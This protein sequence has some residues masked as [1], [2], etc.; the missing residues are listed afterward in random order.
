[1]VQAA[2]PEE[3]TAAEVASTRTPPRCGPAFFEN[4]PEGRFKIA[5]PCQHV[6]EELNAEKLDRPIEDRTMMPGE[7][8]PPVPFAGRHAC[9]FQSQSREFRHLVVL[10]P[11]ERLKASNILRRDH[12]L[13]KE[14]MQ[15]VEPFDAVSLF[16]RHPL[17]R[18]ADVNGMTA[19]AELL[20]RT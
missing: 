8:E 15:L 5:I 11:G 10:I 12:R 13:M 19:P 20:V 7:F 3:T 18:F 16:A 6:F 4:A 1:M 17:A 9:D 2:F 14:P